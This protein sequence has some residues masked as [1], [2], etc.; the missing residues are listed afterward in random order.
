MIIAKTKLRKMPQSCSKCPFSRTDGVFTTSYRIC[1]FT[2]TVCKKEKLLGTAWKYARN[3]DCPFVYI[4][5]E[6]GK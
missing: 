4:A 1:S 5:E 2:E 6:K 3:S